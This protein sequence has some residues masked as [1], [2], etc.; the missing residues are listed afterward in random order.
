MFPI[1]RFGF[2]WETIDYQ[3]AARYSAQAFS[4]WLKLKQEVC[5]RVFFI[6]A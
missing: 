3:R 5:Q 2:Y 4:Y 6:K 1:K